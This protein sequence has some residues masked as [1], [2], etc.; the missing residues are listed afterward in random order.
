MLA[1]AGPGLVEALRV[2]DPEGRVAQYRVALRMAYCHGIVRTA[3]Q[4]RAAVPQRLIQGVRVGA[5]FLAL[6]RDEQ[7]AEIHGYNSS[8]GSI[9]TRTGSAAFLALRTP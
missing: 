6:Q 7:L 5:P 9:R 2:L 3:G 4:H 1:P 8:N